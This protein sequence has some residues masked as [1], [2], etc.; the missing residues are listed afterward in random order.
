MV[1]SM[2]TTDNDASANNAEQPQSVKDLSFPSLRCRMLG[3]SLSKN[4][5]PLYLLAEMCDQSGHYSEQELYEL[6]LFLA[7]HYR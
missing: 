2:K 3:V 5:Y 6:L 7:A 4:G 1:I